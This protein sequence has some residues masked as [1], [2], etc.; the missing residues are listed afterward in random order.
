[1]T[2]RFWLNT[3][4]TSLFVSLGA[5]APDWE[6]ERVNYINTEPPRATFIPFA[7]VASALEGNPEA[8]PF[9]RSLN[10]TWK[11]HWIPA[12]DLRP[13]NFFENDFDDSAW[14][15]IDVP[16]CVEMEGHGTPIY[17][18]A[19]YPFKIDPPRVTSGPPTNSTAFAQR[20]P[21]SSYRRAFD[22]PARWNDRRVFIHFDGV[23]SAFYVWINGKRVGYSENSRSPAEF[24]ITRFVKPGANQIAVEVYRWSDG[25]YL[26][27]QDMWRMSGIFRDVY[28]YSTAAARIRDFA[29]RM[30]LDADYRDAT[31]QIKP[32]L[33]DYANR[34]LTNWTVRAHLYDAKK[35]PVLFFESSTHPDLP[36]SRRKEA[37][38]KTKS[39]SLLTSAATVVAH[40]AAEILNRDWSAKILDDR[41]PQ[42]GPSKFA[43]MEGTISNPLKWTAET[44]NLYTL[45][46]TLCNESG[47]IVEADSCQIG[48]RKIEIRDGR[49]LINGLPVRLR[50][51]NRHE[52]DPDTGH[53]VSLASMARDIELMKRAN[54]NAVRTSHYPND[55]R[56]YDLCD[57]YG[58]YVMD[59]ANLETHGTRG[60]LANDPRW[61]NAFLER[62]IALAERD[63]NHPSVIIWSLGNESGYGP[64]FAAMAAWLREFDPTRPIHYEGAQG[65][66]LNDLRREFQPVVERGFGG[67]KMEDA[68]PPR[69]KSILHPPSSILHPPSLPPADPPGVD[70]ISRFYPRVMEPYAKPDSPENTR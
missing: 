46:L 57:R 22:L 34:S 39:Q 16:S 49:F 25:S 11:F 55:P 5:A 42:R 66:R 37:H 48:F 67:S 30:E 65:Y 17:V 45:V 50:G 33:A 58:L 3:F 60:F 21:I 2:F 12:P 59:E 44:P 20:N 1:M 15:T 8:S 38:S 68:R 61:A 18:S 53:S 26:E 52:T 41:T 23:E 70:I 54:I 51:V 36:S 14:N 40:D 9:F 69:A 4:A 62:A 7:D 31:L 63:K 64:N 28:L 24:D 19:G 27:D 13:T 35:Q 10:G 29:V 47:T 56:W 43:W 32:E 6:N